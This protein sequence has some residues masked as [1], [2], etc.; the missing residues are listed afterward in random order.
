MKKHIILLIALILATITLNSQVNVDEY[1][2]DGANCTSIMVGRKASTDGSV[3]TSHTC[4]SWYRTW[5]RWEPAAD[6]EDNAW[7]PVYK[8]TMHTMSPSETKGLE[9]AAE[10]P[11]PNHTYAYL[12]TAYPCFNEKQLAI[13]ETTFSGP[14]T[15]RNK[16]GAFLIEELERVALQRCDNARDAIKT[17]AEFI[18][19]YG[20]GDSG[21]AI[22]IADTKEVWLM[23]IMGEGP[24]KIGGI[25]AAQRVP[26]GEVG[27]SAN[28]PRIKYLNR[29][30]EKN[31]M[32]SD[33]VEEVAKKYGLWDGEGKFIW[34]KAFASSY[35]NGKNFREREWFI[36]NELAPSL[37]LDRDAEDIPFSVKPENKVDVRDVMRLLRSYYE[38]SDM[39]IT[40]N[41]KIVTRD[42]DTIVS[43]T[44]NPWMGGNEQKVY[45]FLK[46][47]TIEFKRGVAMSWCSY[48]FV[49][50][51]RDWMPD[52]IGG[53]CWIGVENPGQSPRIPVYSGC[54][55]M[56]SCFDRCGHGNYDEQT[57]LWRYRKANK[58]AQVN[59]GYAKD[60]MY[61]NIQRYE[62]KAFEEMPELEKK[63]EKLLKKGERDEAIKALNRY[64]ADFEAA[65]AETWK[66]MEHHF[67]EKFW[68]GF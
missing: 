39:D 5:M 64:T 10:I 35:S 12:N 27:I 65:T 66:E 21:E 32:C 11:L 16:N 15:L 19:E 25:W 46:P 57:A 68:T 22:T 17:I 14:D 61:N 48:S 40:R 38:G 4:D 13:G 56:P 44:A 45:N 63:V 67:W 30:D 52:E 3:M 2:F 53:I 37:K 49:A 33:N 41:L 54:T 28:I 50:Q 1:E 20:Y 47:G 23:E 24:D 29:K 55:K 8:G 60:I 62:D 31:F 42:G 9:V 59:W 51:L 26:D 43:P 6:Y 7:A 36:F 18:K 34:Y 58:L